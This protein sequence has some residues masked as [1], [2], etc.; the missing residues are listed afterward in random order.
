MAARIPALQ[1]GSHQEG[2]SN[3]EPC[4]ICRSALGRRWSVMQCGHNFC[5]DCIKMICST[6]SCSRNGS[7]LCAVCRTSC[8]HGDVFYVETSRP[9]QARQSR[10]ALK[11]GLALPRGSKSTMAIGP[12]TWEGQVSLLAAAPPADKIA[13][14]DCTCHG[15][16]M[17]SIHVSVLLKC[18]TA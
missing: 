2:E 3:P 7:L 18:A 12:P 14:M 9:T 10:F 11:V 4:P 6:P 16:F 15:V 17:C 1:A 5:M 8:A 13:K